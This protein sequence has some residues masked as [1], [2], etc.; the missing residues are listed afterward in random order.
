MLKKLLSAL[1]IATL[2]LG[3][4]ASAE[5]FLDGKADRGIRLHKVRL[6]EVEEGVS[7]TTGLNLEDVYVPDGAKGLAV[8][9]RYLPMLVQIDN[10]EG[11]Y[12]EFAPWGASYADIIYETP[13]HSNGSTRISFLFSDVIPASA[14]P[15]RSARVGHA[16]LRE[17][18]DAGFLYYGAQTRQGSD[19]NEV[20][21]KTGANKKGVLFSGIV[22]DGKPWKQFYS[23][24]AGIPAPHNVDANVAAISE[25]IPAE[26]EAPNHAYEFTDEMPQGDSATH[27]KV[28]WS[29]QGYGSD[30][31]YDEDSG[32]YLR[33]MRKDDVNYPYVD[34]DTG[35]QLA[36]SNVIVQF[37]NVKFNGSSA[38][39]VTEHIGKGPADFFMGGQHITGMWKRA[40]GTSRTVFYGPDGHEMPMLRGRTLI[41]C[42]PT[43]PY[44]DKVKAMAVSYE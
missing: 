27:V 14:G 24:R 31:M 22:G 11:G 25:L 1:L 5:T 32:T 12:G 35:E 41:I 36:F 13:L 21:K 8:T 2:L 7:P 17:E 38:A 3:A 4:A 10:N 40:D 42:F 6:N 18:W 33:Y 37:V 43:A 26:H 9:G 20:F 44:T 19:V 30:L 29:H 15:V 23:R 28:N 16:W 39:P 34:L